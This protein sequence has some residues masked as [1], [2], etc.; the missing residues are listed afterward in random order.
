MH[1]PARARFDESVWQMNIIAR[2]TQ[3]H[4]FRCVGL[5]VAAGA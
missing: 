4:K 5:H 3:N 1:D 2:Y